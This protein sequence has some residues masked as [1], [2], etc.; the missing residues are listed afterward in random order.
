[1]G[2]GNSNLGN[3]RIV[4]GH[5][6]KVSVVK[7]ILEEGRIQKV[8]QE[9]IEKMSITSACGVINLHDVEVRSKKLSTTSILSVLFPKS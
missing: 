1:M 4:L 7:Q 3:N 2:V 8:K 6:K 5:S 9:D